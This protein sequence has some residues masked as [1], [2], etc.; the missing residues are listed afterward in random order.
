MTAPVVLVDRLEDLPVPRAGLT[1]VRTRD[2][3]TDPKWIEAGRVR[4]LNLSRD[5]VYLG[6]GYYASL[7]AEVRGH[8]VLPS[9]ATVLRMKDRGRSWTAVRAVERVVLATLARLKERPEASFSIDVY[10][11]QA[12]DP[13]FRNVARAAFEQFRTPIQRVQVKLDPDSGFYVKG[14]RARTVD[15][16]RADEAEMFAAAV[17]DFTR[18]QWRDPKGPR[19]VRYRLAVLVDPKEEMPPSDPVALKRLERVGAAM[20]VSVETIRTRDYGRVPEFDALFIRMTTGIDNPTYR[21][22]R[23][24]EDEGMPVIDDPTSIL[25]CTNKVYLAEVLAANKV[26]AP[27]TLVLDHRGLAR[28]EAT[29]GFPMVLKIPDGSFSRGVLKAENAPQL[30]RIATKLFEDSDL[31]LAQEF[32]PTDFDWRVGVLDGA[33]LFVCQYQMAP[34]HW[35]IYQHGDDGKTKGGGFAT[36][37]IEDTPADVLETAMA[38]A[39]LMGDGLYGVDLKQNSQGVFVVEVNDNPNIDSGVEDRIS[40]DRLYRTLL[41]SFVRRIEA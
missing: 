38:A 15:D 8:S 36:L 26:A 21:F 22:A 3:L 37:A 40:K 30:R 19:P 39:N 33:P 32:M 25:R 7:L 34:N 17:E 18:R 5:M 31:I 41:E 29:L 35:Q 1:V 20:G 16:L 28:A 6:L 27:R 12:A 13:R 9:A 14:V 11:G 23:K 2:Y 10:L 4:I 24:A